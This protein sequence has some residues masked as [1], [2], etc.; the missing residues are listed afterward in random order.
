[1][2]DATRSLFLDVAQN[3]SQKEDAELSAALP[4]AVARARAAA[5]HWDFG[6][7]SKIVDGCIAGIF[8]AYR[9]D[10]LN[11]IRV[12][13]VARLALE[14]SE[15]EDRLP[16][17]VL[18]LYPSFLDRV[19]RFLANTT[20]RTY[21]VDFYCKDV[22][23][24]LGLTVP[25]GLLQIDLRYS[26]GPKLILREF[27]RSGLPQMSCDLLPLVWGR[28]Y[29]T[30][31][32]PRDMGEFNLGGW[33]ASFCRIGETL[34]LNS[35]VRGAAGASWFYDPMVSQISPE[36]AYMR[37]NQISSGAFSFY[38]GDAP[39]HTKNA[40]YAS[41]I[42]QDLYAEGKYLPAAYLIAWPR[43]RLIDWM[44]SVATP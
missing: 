15:V 43:R 16:A 25:C 28:W 41:R 23:Y 18:A 19:A 35:A 17:S 32:D 27:M 6:A 21:K 33:T 29:N 2:T 10:D 44:R 3:V 5:A 40:L 4:H 12:A 13:V 11:R 22:R 34:E 1:M 30:H 38:L 9:D 36:L 20:G 42:R 24:A 37:R 26:I 14:H 8:P 39:H 31:L 7:P